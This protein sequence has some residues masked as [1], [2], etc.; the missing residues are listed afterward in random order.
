M[1]RLK[2][3]TVRSPPHV[4]HLAQH[5]ACPF[6]FI[7]YTVVNRGRQIRFG[8][9]VSS[10]GHIGHPQQ[11]CPWHGQYF[12]RGTAN[13]VGLL[14]RILDDP[15]GERAI[16][17]RLSPLHREYRRRTWSTRRG[18]QK[19]LYGCYAGR[20]CSFIHAIGCC[21]LG[22]YTHAQYVTLAPFPPSPPHL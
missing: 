9:V 16:L 19:I 20:W 13:A 5:P 8:L 1:R 18:R 2:S 4:S 6:D 22:L 10:Q 7:C 3:R 12:G 15:C 21:N 14:Q 11:G 17:D